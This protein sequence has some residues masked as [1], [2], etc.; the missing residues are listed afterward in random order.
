MKTGENIA[1]EYQITQD[2]QTIQVESNKSKI[3]LGIKYLLDVMFSLVGLIVLMPIILIFSI[4]IILES[5]GSPFYLQERLGLNGK[6]FKVIKL[7]S[8]RSDAEKNGAKWAEKNDPRVTKIGLF[9]RKTRID[10]LPQLFNILKGDM[11]LVGPRPER[12]IFT[13]EFERDIPGFKKRLEVKPGLTGWAQVNG[14]YE[15]TPREKL[16]LDVYYINHASIILD[17]KIIIKTVRVV[18]TGDGAR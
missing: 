13:E 5:P 14:G 9:I 3:Y 15:I 4:L 11:S 12:P 7:R 10:E 8:M 6:R 16:N 18:I 17:F 1:R 2:T